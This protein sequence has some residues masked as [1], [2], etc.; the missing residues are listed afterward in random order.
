V[1]KNLPSL[2]KTF[3]ITISNDNIMYS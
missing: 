1:T 3:A 2:I